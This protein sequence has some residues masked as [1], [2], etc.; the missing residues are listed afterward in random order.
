MG[1]TQYA[2]YNR[3]LNALHEMLS[4][5]RDRRIPPTVIVLWGETGMGKTKRAYDIAEKS[6]KPFYV[7]P[8]GSKWW[9]GYNGQEVCIIDEIAGQIPL[10]ELLMWLDR[11][12]PPR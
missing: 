8:S 1:I 7:K 4:K 12:V 11:C 9:N 5:H 6:G 2:R 3:G 10:A